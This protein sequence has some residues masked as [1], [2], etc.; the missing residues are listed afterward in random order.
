MLNKATVAFFAPSGVMINSGL[1]AAFRLNGLKPSLLHT[2]TDTNSLK[3][4]AE[5]NVDVAG[6]TPGSLEENH[7]MSQLELSRV[8]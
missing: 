8:R 6:V 5:R 7:D 4:Y 1:T 2:D 3:A